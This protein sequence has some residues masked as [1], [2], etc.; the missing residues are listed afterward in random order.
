MAR[1]VLTSGTLS[2]DGNGL[3]LDPDRLWT[4]VFRPEGGW[5]IARW[6]DVARIEL[7]QGGR[8]SVLRARLSIFDEADERVFHGEVDFRDA[9]S[10]LTRSAPEYVNLQAQQIPSRL[11]AWRFDRT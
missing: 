11:S 4:G 7:R 10:L 1:W 9:R 6:P 5:Y 8:Y 2:V 3:R